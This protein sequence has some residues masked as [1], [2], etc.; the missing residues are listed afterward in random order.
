[1]LLDRRVEHTRKLQGFLLH[2]P[3]YILMPFDGP[4]G[5]TAS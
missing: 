3:N 4:T 2:T 1:M 5:F